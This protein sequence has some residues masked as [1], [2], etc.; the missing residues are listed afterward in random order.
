MASFV[1]FFPILIQQEGGYANQAADSGGETWEGI[2]RNNYPKWQGWA[3]V[4]AHKSKPDFPHSLHSDTA[5]EAMVECFYKC[6]EWNEVKA[7]Q[8]QNQSIANYLVDWGVNAGMSVPVKHAQKI[9]N[10][11]QDGIVGPATL[12]GIN[13]ACGECFFNSMKGERIAFYQ[14]V[15]QSHPEDHVFLSQWLSRANSFSFN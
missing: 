11:P 14:A 2:S 1:E 6:N 3:L 13:G 9:L 5:L 12:A 8:I 7:D 15:V 10:L 4:D